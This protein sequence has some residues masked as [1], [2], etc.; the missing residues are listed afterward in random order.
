MN[1]R[2]NS[3]VTRLLERYLALNTKNRNAGRA[4]LLN[5]STNNQP[6]LFEE[7]KRFFDLHK[8]S[9]S[10][11]ED[12]RQSLLQLSKDDQEAFASH[13]LTTSKSAEPA[14]TQNEKETS[15]WILAAT[16]SL[17]ISYLLKISKPGIIE[18]SEINEYVLWCLKVYKFS[19]SIPTDSGD[20]AAILAVM[21]LLKIE[22]RQRYVHAVSPMTKWKM[23]S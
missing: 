14:T 3:K 2:A 6:G 11:F 21:A 1:R 20:D 4:S 17:K 5:Q 16:N 22:G 23:S 10:C 12:L 18:S 19:A 15:T 8:S 9:R 13:T 7:C